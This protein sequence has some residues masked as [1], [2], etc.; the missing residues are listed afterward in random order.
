MRYR[1]FVT[2]GTLHDTRETNLGRPNSQLPW[3]PIGP[4]VVENRAST[5]ASEGGGLDKVQIRRNPVPIH[6]LRRDHGHAAE[7]HHRIVFLLS[8]VRGEQARKENLGS[9]SNAQLAEL[10]L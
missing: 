1:Y 5:V 6:L 2:E 7:P 3:S 4:K 8:Y 10:L 9:L